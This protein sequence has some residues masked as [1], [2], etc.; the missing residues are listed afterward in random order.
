MKWEYLFSR[1]I[2]ERGRQYYINNKVTNPVVS[3]TKY[4]AR[5]KGSQVYDVVIDLN[6]PD[7][8]KL[9]CN[10]PYAVDGNRCKHMAAVLYE[11]ES[12]MKTSA[13]KSEK[14]VYPFKRKN[15]ADEY[16]YFD[17][18]RITS[19]LIITEKLYDDAKNILDK[20]EVEITSVNY[21]YSEEIG[22]GQLMC[23]ARGIYKQGKSQGMI[24]ITFSRDNI[25][26]SYCQ[27]PRCRMSYNSMYAR[28][29]EIKPCEHMTAFLLLLDQYLQE[30]D[31]YDSTDYNALCL[32]RSYRSNNAFDASE[33]LD[34]VSRVTLEPRVENLLDS[35]KLS[36]MIGTDKL[37]VV[38][39]L[40]ELVDIVDNKKTLAL[41]KKA[42]L[43]FGV[44]RF[45]ESSR[46]YYDFIRR[47]VLEELQRK[48]NMRYS[49]RSYMYSSEEIK[50]SINL[51]GGRL[52]DFFELAEGSSV[53]CVDKSGHDTE[54]RNITLRQNKPNLSL[55]ITKDVDARNVFHG[56]IVSGKV[57][58]MMQ[59]VKARYYIEGNYFNKVDKESLKELEPVFELAKGERILFHIGRRHLSEFYYRVLPVL[60]ECAQIEELD[61]QEIEKYIPPEASFLFYMDAEDN[62][63]SCR[64]CA[65]YGENSC[66]LA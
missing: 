22:E 10:C 2:C 3:G 27:A 33:K 43:D 52:D 35:L 26:V 41:G 55:V 40:S 14:R 12:K 34:A 46:K 17:M 5:V 6:D 13:T 9:H 28:S 1:T 60:Q 42:E 45:T 23:F 36:F 30:N 47:N 4:H 19:K 15:D 20:G 31:T 21:G 65:V 58:M 56:V 54:K 11:I 53:Y 62:R 39:N 8:P 50:G 61:T 38:K 57:P 44:C 51:Y 18:E 59:G 49:Y 25:A 64:P 63:I 32:M 16:R 24:S 29:R 7:S 66:A 37:Y 48:E